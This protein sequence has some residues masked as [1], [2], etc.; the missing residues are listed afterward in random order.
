MVF[1]F[2]YSH[3]LEQQEQG[4]I[5]DLRYQKPPEFESSS[6]AS[7]RAIRSS[8]SSIKERR[9]PKTTTTTKSELPDDWK[10][11]DCA[12]LREQAEGFGE[13]HLRRLLKLGTT[14]PDQIQENINRISYAV[15]NKTQTFKKT[16]IAML[17]GLCSEGKYF[18]PPK[19]YGLINQPDKVKSADKAKEP[20]SIPQ[21]ETAAAEAK[22]QI[23]A[24][25]A[26]LKEMPR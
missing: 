14:N 4:V 3:F 11:I 22:R 20:Q 10:K 17:M 26:H 25:T 5:F 6:R 18:D 13:D 12:P 16:P 19:G 7:S 1:E 8:S 15:K 2:I 21:E 9:D 24:L 23:A